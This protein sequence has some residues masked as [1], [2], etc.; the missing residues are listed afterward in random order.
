MSAKS[1]KANASLLRER[2]DLMK[3]IAGYADFIR[4]SVFSR[5]S[6]CSRP[7]C[8]C[9]KG[10]RHGPRFYLVTTD[11]S[12][13]RQHYIPMSKVDSIKRATQQS[14]EILRLLDLVSQINIKLMRDSESI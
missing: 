12:K 1:S 6:T 8:A 5:F 10:K 11:G 9:H 2:S 7:S 14:K 13:Q 4:G 3:Q